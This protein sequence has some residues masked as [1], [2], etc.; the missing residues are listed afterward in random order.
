MRHFSNE[1]Q[2]YRQFLRQALDCMRT[3]GGIKKA[4]LEANGA[5]N[6]SVVLRVRAFILQAIELRIVQGDVLRAKYTLDDAQKEANKLDPTSEIALRDA[7][8][9]IRVGKGEEPLF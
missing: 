7:N 1:K 4:I 2:L 6:S 5:Y 8:I 3:E 9:W